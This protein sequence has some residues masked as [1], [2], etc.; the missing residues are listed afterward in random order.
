VYDNAAW[1]VVADNQV[2]SIDSA[3]G[4]V[5]VGTTA[6]TVAL[7]VD[8]GSTDQYAAPQIYIAPSGHA[9]SD[10]AAIQL[11]DI[12]LLTDIFGNGAEDFSIYSNGAASHRLVI[13]SSGSVG[14][15][16]TTPAFK[17][18]AKGQV[19]IGA[20][21]NITPDADGNGHLMIDGAGYTGFASLDGT[22]MWVGHNSALRDL[23]LATDETARMTIDQSGRVTMPAQPF[24]QAKSGGN[25][26]RATAG[27]TWTELNSTFWG[28]NWVTSQNIGSH[29]N[30]S[31]GRFTAPVSGVY[32]MM[33]TAYYQTTVSGT[34]SYVHPTLFINGSYTWNNGQQPYVIYGY[35]YAGLNNGISLSYTFYLSEGD[36]VAPG[37]YFRS[38]GDQF[39]AG[40][41]YLSAGL[42]H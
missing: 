6:P 9:S 1:L 29:F 34:G 20:D 30:T 28:A 19:Q 41:S 22:A 14:I 15:G 17:L 32:F 12:Q 11:D 23:H 7:Q 36:Y 33:W 21:D 2:L 5:G 27:S 4:R 35:S 37:A 16:T 3:N 26:W 31:T 8:S 10:R 25:N 38:T 39:H 24:V 13:D 42:L 40:Y 18:D